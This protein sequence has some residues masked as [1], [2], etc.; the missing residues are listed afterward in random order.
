[1]IF[2]ISSCFSLFFFLLNYRNKVPIVNRSRWRTILHADQADSPLDG[3][4]MGVG[5]AFGLKTLQ[6]WEKDRSKTIGKENGTTK[7]E[8]VI[9][10]SHD[11]NQS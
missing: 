2:C 3:N 9:N 11:G 10:L 8:D 6:C 4:G 1:M 5:K 7:R